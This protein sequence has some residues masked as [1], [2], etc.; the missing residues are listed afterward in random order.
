M[1]MSSVRY[2]CV[3]VADGCSLSCVQ[4]S[5]AEEEARLREKREE[6][7]GVSGWLPGLSVV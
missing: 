7:I 4:L 1:M 2:E 6:Y 3:Y 5:A